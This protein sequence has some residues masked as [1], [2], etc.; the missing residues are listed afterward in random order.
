MALSCVWG[1]GGQRYRRHVHC[2]LETSLVVVPWEALQQD[3]VA[4]R[5][6]PRGKAGLQLLGG[7]QEVQGDVGLP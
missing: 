7:F 4:G 6:V 2:V 3:L 5:L 1:C